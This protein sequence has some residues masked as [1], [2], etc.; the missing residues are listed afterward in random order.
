[1]A[2]ALIIVLREV[3][4][5]GLI[6]GIVL[7]ATRTLPSRGLYVAGGILA[8]LLGAALV[9]AFAGT[10]ANALAGVG[11]EVFNAAILGL[12]VIMLGWHNIWMARHGRQIGEDLRRLGRDVLSGSRSLTALA[13]V[14]AVAVLREGS[15]V[16]LF[17]YGVVISSGES[18][19]SLVLGGLL[20]LLLGAGISAVT[21]TGLAVIPP[22]HLFRVTSVLIGFMAAGMAAQSVAFLEQADIATALG[23]AV[24]NTS[25]VLADNSVAGRVLHTLLGY[26]D[27]PTELQL[28]V[29][30]ATLGT[31]F[32]L[33]KLLAPPP[34]QNRKLATN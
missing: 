7:A 5:A 13:I 22:R 3:V 33:M 17:L 34:G 21:Y 24:W 25:L 4:E 9:A 18:G 2:G 11:Q 14:V 20:G 31:I 32:G 10:L 23:D 12:A 6:V 16:V 26:S 15:E 28:V 27:K 30:L 19:L 29:Y 1:M 8:G